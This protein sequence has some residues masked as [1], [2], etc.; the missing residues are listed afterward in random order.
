MLPLHKGVHNRIKASQEL[1]CHH[2]QQIIIINIQPRSLD[3]RQHKLHPKPQEGSN[4]RLLSFQQPLHLDLQLLQISL[5]RRKFTVSTRSK[6]SPTGD[7]R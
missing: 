1:C 5:H 2:R 6:Y 3:H 7:Y 4:A